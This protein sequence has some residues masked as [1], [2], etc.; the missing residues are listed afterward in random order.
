MHCERAREL[1]VSGAAWP[2]RY[3]AERH[4]RDCQACAK[5]FEELDQMAEML[6]RIPHHE[7]PE[8]LA[9]AMQEAAQFNR[10]DATGDLARTGTRLNTGRLTMKKLILVTASFAIAGWMAFFVFGGKGVAIADLRH[11]LVGANVVHIVGD[12]H[13]VTG[14]A[15]QPGSILPLFQHEDKWLRAKPFATYESITMPDSV[16]ADA[17]HMTIA[18]NTESRFWYFVDQNRFKKSPGLASSFYDL[19]M[20][21]IHPAESVDAEYKVVGQTTI[22]GRNLDLL[23]AHDG[24]YTIELAVDP[25]TE[26]TFRLRQF[27]PGS[28]EIKGWQPGT[29]GKLVMVTNLRFS[30]D[31]EAPIGVFDWQPPKDAVSIQTKHN[32]GSKNPQKEPIRP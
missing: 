32:T 7:M 8:R 31:E 26:R 17:R 15:G 12:E 20:G 24:D 25:R 13:S 16:P 5:W 9:Q 27:L 29:G 14:T 6:K 3:R 22:E 21:I 10:P 28:V 23:E 4:L 1:L 30:Y 19:M 2:R 18:G 11:G